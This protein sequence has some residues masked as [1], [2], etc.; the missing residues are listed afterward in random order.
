MKKHLVACCLSRCIRE[1]QSKQPH[2]TVGYSETNDAA[3]IT[4]L[5]LQDLDFQVLDFKLKDSVWKHKRHFDFFF[6]LYFEKKKELWKWTINYI[7]GIQEQILIFLKNLMASQNS[8]VLM[9][10]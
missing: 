5:Y 3:K 4:E 9:K 7:D 1:D 8:G 10:K 2:L 6:L